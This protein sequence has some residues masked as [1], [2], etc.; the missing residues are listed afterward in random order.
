[1]Y[2]FNFHGIGNPGPEVPA[3]EKPYWVSRE[4]FTAYAELFGRHRD[5]VVLTF[6][7]GNRSDLEIAAPLLLQQG[8]TARI[9]VLT[10]RFGSAGYLQPEDLC[11]LRDMGFVIGSHGID[12]IDWAAADPQLLAQEVAGSKRQIEAAL[13]ASIS[14]A[15]VPFGSYAKRVLKAL[16][17][18][19]YRAVWTS[20]GVLTRN[21][22]FLRPRLS[23]RSDTPFAY[24]TQILTE[25]VP[26]RR[27]LRQHASIARKRLI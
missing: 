13:G 1:M 22:G 17:R 2:A 24:V 19:E 26:F 20:D 11:T 18:A 21:E 10:G 12:H 15:A 14:E 7:D 4:A 16:R 6:D 23:I 3:G 8:L 25:G 27:R 9:F 5:R